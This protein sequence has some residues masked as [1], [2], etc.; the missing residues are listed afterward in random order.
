MSQFTTLNYDFPRLEQV[1][2][3]QLFK[4]GVPYLEKVA[5]LVRPA[6]EQALKRTE[7][8]D[9]P[10]FEAGTQPRIENYQNF[11][12]DSVGITF[13]YD[14][15]QVAAYAAG[16]QKITIEYERFLPDLDTSGPLADALN[17]K[18]VIPQ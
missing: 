14:P 11:T 1:E 10:V 4:A 18:T 7:D 12:L 5:A 17:I 6:L 8:F 16:P 15:Y 3:S 9:Q 13:Y 2:L